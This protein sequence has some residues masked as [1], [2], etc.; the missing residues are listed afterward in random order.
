MSESGPIV[1]AQL[2]HLLA[3]VEQRRNERCREVLDKARDQAR[4]VIK[5]AYH[6]ERERMHGELVEL[7]QK[8]R[9]QMV[10]LAARRETRKRQQRQRADEELLVRSWQL[11]H[12]ALLHRWRDAMMR[13]RWVEDVVQQA[14]SVL[15]DHHWIIE[16]P[17]DWPAEERLALQQLLEQ[18]SERALH[19][20]GQPKIAAG[21]RICAGGA[22]VDASV[23]G[24][25]R[26]R[27][28]IEAVLLARINERRSGQD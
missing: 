19:F 5:Q 6:D 21:L 13:R 20:E 4:Q 9:Q 8:L 7:R 14:A 25:L 3:V 10:S 27:L 15:I 28:A 26:E 2:Q 23:D 12:E 24:L 16:H 1:A 17:T 11:L 18:R 22:C